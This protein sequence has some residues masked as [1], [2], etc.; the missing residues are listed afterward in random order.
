METQTDPYPSLQTV[1][2]MPSIAIDQLFIYLVIIVIAIVLLALFSA[3]E[4]AVLR[5]REK[6]IADLKK[7]DT[8]QEEKLLKLLDQPMRPY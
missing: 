5:I 4:K 8:K 2:H 3:A 6:D 7:A 1:G